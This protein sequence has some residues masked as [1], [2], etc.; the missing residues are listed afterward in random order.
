MPMHSKPRTD[1]PWDIDE[2]RKLI[3]N[4]YSKKSLKEIATDHKRTVA[5]IQAQQREMAADYWFND[6][7]PLYEI[8]QFT[9]LSR[10]VVANAIRQRILSNPSVYQEAAPSSADLK[11]EIVD[12]KQE[13]VSLKQDVKEMLT[14][15]NA[16]YKFE[17]GE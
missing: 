1:Q 11:Q 9:G 17:S 2:I 6:H 3:A 16:I 10:T 14:C 4:L 12:L 15:I 8:A 13:I 7:R 5:A